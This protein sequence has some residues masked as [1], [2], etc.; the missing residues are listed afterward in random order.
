MIYSA[1]GAV[2]TGNSRSVQYGGSCIDPPVKLQTTYKKRYTRYKKMSSAKRYHRRSIYAVRVSV[3]REWII[4]RGWIRRWVL[5][6]WIECYHRPECGHR[7][8]WTR[9]I[10]QIENWESHPRGMRDRA[11]WKADWQHRD[12]WNQTVMLG[13]LDQSQRLLPA[14]QWWFLRGTRLSQILLGIHDCLTVTVYV[15]GSSV[16]VIIQTCGIFNSWILT[17][18]TVFTTRWVRWFPRG[19]NST[20]VDW[21]TSF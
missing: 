14:P 16:H 10:S 2:N 19:H 9:S 17:L 4:T 7:H 1:P 5:D 3:L 8:G 20:T 12:R 21:N 11:P 18:L 13:L 15:Q 6:E